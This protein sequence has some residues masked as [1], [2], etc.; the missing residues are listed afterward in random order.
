MKMKSRKD[1]K[2]LTEATSKSPEANT[3]LDQDR[4]VHPT[5]KMLAETR[6]G[7]TNQGNFYL[8]SQIKCIKIYII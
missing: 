6:R 5:T 7:M 8:P 1:Q 2:G 3:D 4:G